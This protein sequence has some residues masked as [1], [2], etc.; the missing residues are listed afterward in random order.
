MDS[1]LLSLCLVNTLWQKYQKTYID[2]FVPLMVTTLLKHEILTFS[3]ND[4]DKIV[5]A[6]VEDYGI[7]LPREPAIS[8]LGRCKKLGIIRHIGNSL[9]VNIQNA[10]KF[11]VSEDI[12][13]NSNNHERLCADFTE[14]VKS[15]YSDY[16]NALS[17]EV[18]SGLM[19]NFIENNDVSLFFLYND[20]NEG[21]LPEPKLPHN[22]KRYKH[23]FSKYVLYAA[24]NN[25]VMFRVI[26]DMVLGSI[27]THALL[28]SFAK[29]T[30]DTLKDCD[31]YL[32]TSL[33]LRL[34]GADENYYT[35]SVSL[36]LESIKCSGGNL[37]IFEHTYDEAKEALDA[38][39]EWVESPNFDVTKA[40]R[41]TL[42]FRQ[43]GYTRSHV[44]LIRASLERKI[45]EFG[46]NVIAKPLYSADNITIDETE[47]QEIFENEIKKHDASFNPVKYRSRTQR[48]VDSIC[49]IS[50]LRNNIRYTDS[51]QKAKY[52]FTTLNGALV[53]ANKIYNKKH[54]LNKNNIYEAVSD[55]FLGTYLWANTPQIAAKTNVAR[56]KAVAL[57]AIKPDADMEYA[58]YQAAKRLKDD[59]RIKDDDYILVNNSHLV[60]DLLSEKTIGDTT[61]VS[62]NTVFDIL[63][64][65]KNRIIGNT[66]V[67]L[68]EVTA[69]FEEEQ[70]L[71][72]AAEQ[73]A[74]EKE[75]Q[76]SMLI[77]TLSLKAKNKAKHKSLGFKIGMWILLIASVIVPLLGALL[78]SNKIIALFSAIFTALWLILGANGYTIGNLAD[79]FYA[80]VLKNEKIKLGINT[81]E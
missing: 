17:Y 40:N 60:T 29:Q 21:L 81:K 3:R 15:R 20:R 72:M 23:I 65:V 12:K 48:D 5:E 63:E 52:L 64:E 38:S 66:N 77:V 68:R 28:F 55:I 58:F 9:S 37:K 74:E 71:R 46:I 45:N 76:A 13:T 30:G 56:I 16:A 62:E 35:D 54:N 1:S 18:V 51:I 44:E 14:F 53:I 80:K 61:L 47:F 19:L 50:R 70:K 8:I 7:T 67:E 4:N 36:F 59:K 2:N 11:D 49:A 43:K 73:K 34:I 27:A 57:S 41:A 69:K 32:D 78:S 75:R 24:E 6:F 33:I 10:S 39:L 22:A 31:I 79:K 42:F 26:E 25:P